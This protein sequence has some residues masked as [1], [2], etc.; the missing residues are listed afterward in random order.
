M[1]LQELRPVH[2]F[3]QTHLQEPAFFWFMSDMFLKRNVSSTPDS[4]VLYSWGS[5]KQ[6]EYQERTTLR[7]LGNLQIAL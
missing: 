7:A 6:K 5:P 4:D 2:D 1:S 3:L